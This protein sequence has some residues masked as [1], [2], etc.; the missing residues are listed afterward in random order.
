MKPLPNL[1]HLR[2]LV[3]LHDHGHFGHAAQACFV[4]PVS[5]THLD[6]YKSQERVQRQLQ[7][8]AAV[9][10]RRRQMAGAHVH[11]Q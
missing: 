9:A 3:A 5:Y 8:Q 1:R 4:T 11:L 10:G 6:G 2:Y 7:E